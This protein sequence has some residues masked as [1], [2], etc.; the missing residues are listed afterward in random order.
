MILWDLAQVQYLEE[1]TRLAGVVQA[2][3]NAALGLK[4]RGVR[5][6]PFAVLRG[7]TMPAVLVELGF[8]TNPDEEKLLSNPDHRRKLAEALA[9]AIRQFRTDVA[10]GNGP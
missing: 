3:L 7:A 10:R 5:Q 1:S 9:D 4:D 6:A 2:K 8:I